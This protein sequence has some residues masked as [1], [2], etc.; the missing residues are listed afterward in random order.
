MALKK[1]FALKKTLIPKVE[2]R[3]AQQEVSI[4]IYKTLSGGVGGNTKNYIR[5]HSELKDLQ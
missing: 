2:S 3:L 4:L 1:I 5:F